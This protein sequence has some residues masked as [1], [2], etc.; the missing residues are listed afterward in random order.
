MFEHQKEARTFR[1][2]MGQPND[3]FNPETA[4]LQQR[5]ISEEYEEFLEA[6][7][8]SVCYIQNKRAREACLGELADIAYVCYQYAAAAGWDLDE[9]LTRKHIANLS[10]LDDDLKPIKRADGKVMKGPNY[11]PANLIDLV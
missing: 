7:A 4:R 9:A 11:K 10:K 2:L 6:H 5:L 1:V 8:E 3:S